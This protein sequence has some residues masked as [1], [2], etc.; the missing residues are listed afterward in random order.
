MLYFD[1]TGR[2]IH[3]TCTYC[4]YRHGCDKTTEEINKVYDEDNC[5]DFEV[6]SCFKC[7]RF[8]EGDT[9]VCDMV[10]YPARCKNYQKSL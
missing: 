5:K 10:M 9:T 4:E 8:L 1:K 3:K 2:E 7:K 6:G